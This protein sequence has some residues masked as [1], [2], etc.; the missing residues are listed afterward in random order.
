MK[1][2]VIC[3]SIGLL[4]TPI[5]PVFGQAVIANYS[6]QTEHL[7]IAREGTVIWLAASKA[8]VL[9]CDL[10]GNVL[11]KYTT[12]NGLT[13]NT[14]YDILIDQQGRRWYATDGGISVLNT[15]NNWTQYPY[16]VK[17]FTQA[18][19]GD[20]WAAGKNI[21]LLEASTGNWTILT[22]NWYTYYDRVVKIGPDNTVY[23]GGAAGL[24]VRN[25]I[26]LVWTYYN[27]YVYDWDMG[28]IYRPVQDI[29]F[30]TQGKLW[31][32]QNYGL[33][34]FADSVFSPVIGTLVDNLPNNPVAYPLSLDKL[35]NGNLLIGT[36]NG[37]WIYD[38]TSTLKEFKSR[39]GFR[40]VYDFVVESNNKFWFS[41]DLGFSQF[42]DAD[43][44]HYTP[45]NQML[46][47]GDVFKILIDEAD[48]KWFFGKGGRSVLG[49]NLWDTP[50]PYNYNAPIWAVD[51]SFEPDGTKWFWSRGNSEMHL[52][53]LRND[54]ITLFPSTLGDFGYYT[55]LG[56]D[57]LKKRTIFKSNMNNKFWYCENDSLRQFEIPD[58]DFGCWHPNWQCM[59]GNGNE[60]EIR[61]FFISAEGYYFWANPR[62]YYFSHWG[63][64]N[65]IANI[66]LYILVEKIFY[67]QSA[68]P[69]MIIVLATITTL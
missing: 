59:G 45:G 8:G 28:Y 58:S 2:F 27:T 51:A 3:L 38:G 68:L 56:W 42:E 40:A 49:D 44:E 63:Q 24:A 26:S 33:F 64:S 62:G 21:Y 32:I 57:A 22:F 53:R 16:I 54:S 55:Q 61:H 4:A 1:N 19:N 23:V 41:S 39:P 12:A 25:P 47:S 69:G 15:D 66:P 9:K 37:L 29:E 34:T 65:G 7:A 31:V 30:D 43:F 67:I 60:D 50:Q 46:A 10:T 13:G 11:E 5:V 35:P 20:I 6:K 18:T 52:A 14:I 36:T 17:S 48:K